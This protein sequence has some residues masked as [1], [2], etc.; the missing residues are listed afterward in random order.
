MMP[1]RDLVWWYWLAT[2]PLLMYGL[3]EGEWGFVPVVVLCMVQVLHFL[4]RTGSLA[5][6]PV[7]VRLAY[8][9]ML[10][11]GLWDMGHVIHWLQLI[12]TSAMVLVNYCPLA[13]MMALM[14]WNRKQPLR[15]PLLKQA[16]F[17]APIEGCIVESLEASTNEVPAR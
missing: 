6:F 9:G 17:S 14:P 2:L 16:L 8:L 13:R 11:P 4:L 1:K 15:W 5:A 10:L 12:G 7:Q 3:S